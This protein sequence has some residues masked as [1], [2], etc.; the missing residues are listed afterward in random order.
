MKTGIE[1]IAEERQE[2]IEKHGYDADHDNQ[3]I[4]EYD[5]SD[6]FVSVT[7]YHSPLILAALSYLNVNG[8]KD[9]N[10]S[11]RNGDEFDAPNTDVPEVYIPE[12]WPFNAS[13]WNGTN[14]SKITRLTKAGALIAAEIDRLQNN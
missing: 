11:E 7:E 2:Q 3:H 1:L 8:E 5:Y 14:D 4:G 9:I 13:E 12:L 6:S 10:E